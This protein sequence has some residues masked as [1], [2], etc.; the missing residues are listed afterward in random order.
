MIVMVSSSDAVLNRKT[1]IIAT[2]IALLLGAAAY[3][4]PKMVAA[5]A[6]ALATVELSTQD[7]PAA[8]DHLNMAI[9][10]DPQMAIAYQYRGVVYALINDSEKAIADYSQSLKYGASSDCYYNRAV[11]YHSTGQLDRALKDYQASL[12]ARPAKTGRVYVNMSDAHYRLDDIP[13]ALSE[14]NKALAEDQSDPTALL[15][16]AQCYVYARR[17]KTACEDLSTA[18]DNLYRKAD[19][20][21][22]KRD[23]YLLRG[24]AYSAMKQDEEAESDLSEARRQ[25]AA[26]HKN[27]GDSRKLEADFAQKA[28]RP[29]FILCS[30]LEK[31]ENELTADRL[32]SL[33]SFVDKNV[34]HMRGDRNFHI[35]ALPSEEAYNSYVEKN[36]LFQEHGL[37]LPYPQG[38]QSRYDPNRDAVFTYSL[39]DLSG[40]VGSVMEKEINDLPFCEKWYIRGFQELLDKTYGYADK[41]DCQLYLT[42]D[43]AGYPLPS[44]PPPLIEVISN[45]RPRRDDKACPLLALYLLRAGKSKS[46][47]A[48]AQSGEFSDYASCLEATLNKR[49]AKIE[50]EWKA[51]LTQVSKETLSEKESKNPSSRP[52]HQIFATRQEF[53]KMLAAHPQFKLTSLAVNNPH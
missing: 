2:F 52:E 25:G 7:Y 6:L 13:L 23:I 47:Q 28:V 30:N 11:Q 39:P 4:G 26:Q 15:N 20:Q 51:F 50:P 34:C 53:E 42:Q 35:F 44:P 14:C 24:I 45:S 49:A 37:K 41:N 1:I 32:E 3:C 10:M 21:E 17:Y 40:T 33:I 18:V 19:N 38:L 29:H 22:L 9:Q 48:L 16:R 36:K 8:L 5:S 31:A 46:Y 43:A 27:I 12:N